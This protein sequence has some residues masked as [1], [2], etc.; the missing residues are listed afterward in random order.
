MTYGTVLKSHAGSIKN[1]NIIFKYMA[2]ST[3]HNKVLFMSEAR[4]IHNV[5]SLLMKISMYE[6]GLMCIYLKQECSRLF[7]KI[8][9]GRDKSTKSSSLPI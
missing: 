8:F 2:G 6:N 4:S 7:P 5:L 9:G 3:P 1:N